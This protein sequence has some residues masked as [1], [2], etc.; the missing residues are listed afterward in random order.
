MWVNVHAQIR[1]TWRH[2]FA[3]TK[4]CQMNETWQSKANWK[5]TQH[6]IPKAICHMPLMILVFVSLWRQIT[7][8]IRI[9]CRYWRSGRLTIY[10][11]KTDQASNKLGTPASIY[12]LINLFGILDC[13][14]R[15]EIS[16]L[17]FFIYDQALSTTLIHVLYI[18]QLYITRYFRRS[19]HRWSR[20]LRFTQWQ[21]D[22]SV[23]SQLQLRKLRLLL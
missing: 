4:G 22:I 6:Y 20:I 2:F 19:D 10:N 3:L 18:V 13:K 17:V 7:N 14:H 11:A 23:S 15:V 12:H 8:F 16:T 1:N 9:S 21:F 5:L